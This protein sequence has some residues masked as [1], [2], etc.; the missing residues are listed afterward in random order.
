M[1]VIKYK[2]ALNSLF[3]FQVEENPNDLTNTS[4]NITYDTIEELKITIKKPERVA[5]LKIKGNFSE[6]RIPHNMIIIIDSNLDIFALFSIV[7]IQEG[8]RN[9]LFTCYCTFGV[10]LILWLL[11]SPKKVFKYSN[12]LHFKFVIILHICNFHGNYRNYNHC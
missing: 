6:F 4:S 9:T 11:Q 3:H 10:I 5:S 12:S 7:E 1:I 2:E 8:G